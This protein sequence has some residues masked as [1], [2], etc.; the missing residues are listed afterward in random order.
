MLSGSI[1]RDSKPIFVFAIIILGIVLTLFVAKFSLANA[2]LDISLWF[3]NR[4]FVDASEVGLN[5]AAL[6]ADDAKTHFRLGKILKQFGKYNE[7]AAQFR[8]VIE[9]D[10][11]YPGANYEIGKLYFIGGLK[12]E[13]QEPAILAFTKE[14]EITG[15]SHAYHL[16]GIIYGVQKRWKEAEQD[17]KTEM[18]ISESWGAPLNLAWILFSQGRLSEAEEAMKVVAQKYPGSVWAHNGLGVVYMRQGRLKEAEEELKSAYEKSLQL[19]PEEYF[20]VYS[21]NEDDDPR[22]GIAAIQSGIAFNLGTLYEKKKQFN[23]AALWYEISLEAMRIANSGKLSV[24][25]GLTQNKLREKIEMV[26][27]NIK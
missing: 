13:E 10:P 22:A 14:I 20:Q 1:F 12:P 4:G 27:Q 25:A 15:Y 23:Q 24:A 5:I 26:K 8:K 17:F 2:I 7:A 18:A 11:S 16:R 3:R 21:G 6:L 9:K 19:S